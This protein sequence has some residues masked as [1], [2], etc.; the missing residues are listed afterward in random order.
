MKSKRQLEAAA[1]A[2]ASVLALVT[3][4]STVEGQQPDRLG[5]G[6]LCA[7]SEPDNPAFRSAVSAIIGA[8]VDFFDARMS[9][10]TLD[11]LLMY[12]AVM[13]WPDYQYRDPAAFGN[14]L[15]DYADRG[16]IVILGQGCMTSSSHLLG[17]IMSE[18][19]YNPATATTGAYSSY[20][21]DGVTCIHDGVT[22][23]SAGRD[24]ISLMPGAISDGTWLDGIPAVAFWPHFA[25][26]VFY[27]PGNSGGWYTT[28]DWARLTANMVLC[29][30]LAFPDCN[31]NGID[32]ALDI[33]NCH[34]LP[35]EAR[36]WCWDCQ[37]DGIP[38]GC[39]LEGHDCNNDLILDACDIWCEFSEDCDENGIPDECQCP[40]Q[41]DMDNS[42]EVDGQDVQGFIDCALGGGVNCLCADFDCSGEVDPGDLSEYVTT[43]LT[44]ERRQS[45]RGGAREPCYRP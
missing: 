32:D 37:T 17:R 3:L 23:Y 25:P 10:P 22:A 4:I 44:P 8:P 27:S 5:E 36:W 11:Q 43:L 31:H 42:G 45:A 39:Q 15:A 19:G 34:L 21:G 14:V 18:P 38:D 7:P 35:P 16:G 40:V 28:G 13:T 12:A 24:S 29:P 2:V 26:R 41:G 6:M 20:A 30:T 33:L 1:M 9:T